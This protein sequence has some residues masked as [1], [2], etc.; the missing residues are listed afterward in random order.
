M[1]VSR[2]IVSALFLPAAAMTQVAPPLSPSIK[3]RLDQMESNVARISVAGEKDRWNANVSMW[4]IVFGKSG[5]LPTADVQL[6]ESSLQTIRGN[7]AKV[8]SPA[9]RERWQANIRLWQAFIHGRLS[10]S[11]QP[12]AAM[13]CGAPAEMPMSGMREMA[14]M[15]MSMPGARLATDAAFG[16][17]KL[18]VAR[19]SESAERERWSANSDL[20]EAVLAPAP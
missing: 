8:A 14:S 7:V 15:S 1:K 18:N 17:M 2:L 19:I 11:G 5:K 3:A 6:L 20:W 9:E 12:A 13:P 4:K 10:Q 16:R